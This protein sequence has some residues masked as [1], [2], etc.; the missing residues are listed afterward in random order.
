MLL[1]NRVYEGAARL[2]SIVTTGILGSSLLAFQPPTSPATYRSVL[3]RYCVACHS[4]TTRTAG[5][6][7]DKVD[8]T[9]VSTAA[10]DWEKVL[11]KLRTGT[12]PPPGMP[13]PDGATYA[14]FTGYLED[15]LDKAAAEKSHPGRVAIHRL[16]RTEY[17]N[18]VRDLL[19][20]DIDADLVLPA[21][22][23]GYGFDNIAAVL[24][25]SPILLQRYLSAAK[26]ISRVAIGD[27]N[28]E[29]NR[30]TFTFSPLLKQDRRMSEDLPFASRGGVAFQYNF[31]LDGEYILK[32]RLQ[33]SGSLH[34]ESVIGLS[35]QNDIE[36]RLNGH[37]IKIFHLGGEFQG[38]AGLNTG[39]FHVDVDQS[40][41]E[42]FLR[43][44]DSRLEVRFS[45]KA[46]PQLVGV[47]FVDKHTEPEGPLQSQTAGFRYLNK[48]SEQLPPY[49]DKIILEGPYN[50]TGKG[51]TASRRKIFIC[52]TEA[53][54]DQRACAKKILSR[55]ARQAY[56]RP[57]TSEDVSALLGLYQRGSERAG[58]EAGIQNALE[59]ILISP[60]FIFRT[61]RDPAHMAAG[62]AYRIS[63]LAL[64]SRLSFF[65]WSSIP[66]EEL[67][68][69]GAKG[70]LHE[71]AVLGQQVRRMLADCRSSALVTNFA[72][73]WLHLRKMRSAKPDLAAFPEFDENLREAFEEETN[74]FLESSLREDQSV[75][76]LLDADYTFLNERLA[77]F[78]GIRNVYGTRFRRVTLAGE[79][80]RGLLGQGAVLTVTSYSD[81]TS[82]TLRGKW[83]LENL[84]GAPPPPPPPN[85]PSLR[86]QSPEYGAALT[87]RQ[88]MEEH[89]T[90]PACAGCHARIDPL[91]FAL[92]N[93]DGIG[94]WRTIEGGRPID[95]SG[96][97]PD[98]TKFNGPAEL[99]GILVAHPA[100]F[101]KGLTVKLLTY[102]L[103]RGLEYYDAPA[104]RRILR[105][106][107]PGA[108]KWSSLILGIVDSVPFQMSTA[109]LEGPRTTEKVAFT[110]MPRP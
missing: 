35:E 91:G 56:R 50:P 49:V 18:A 93:F 78:Y 7:L 67:L 71:P 40:E 52:R 88:R 73:Q 22:D 62:T 85:V 12:M 47:D 15:A 92:E 6:A 86:E 102:A 61:E 84:L 43:T 75:L 101:V 45:A 11:D 44:A 99:R 19:A 77:R 33:R 4:E 36:V 48:R 29:L 98:G 59:G 63:D 37:E 10:P 55:L 20:V 89:R 72:A 94:G 42:K 26:K 38:D 8:V 60:E 95:A 1:L 27:L 34:D 96:I 70:V 81:R 13:R 16:N 76:R 2:L 31:P 82:P 103:G 53:E 39:G 80:R 54:T 14:A 100:Q 108:Y 105:D 28:V 65:L 74:L 109:E 24:S 107:S 58:F 64:A 66:D 97:L 68:S 83:L 9:R 3:N 90:N 110:K 23:S 69:L 30:E 79:E 106:A 57:V 5:L 32:I 87:M 25:V 104:V 21:D 17:A 51:E 46:G 41:E